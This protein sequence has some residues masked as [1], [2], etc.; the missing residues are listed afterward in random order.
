[1]LA[2][3]ESGE[4]NIGS[5]KSSNMALLKKSWSRFKVKPDAFWVRLIKSVYGEDGGFKEKGLS[6]KGCNNTWED[7][8]RIGRDL[9]EKEIH[10]AGSF[11]KE[12]GNE[13]NTRFWVDKW[14]GNFRL[15]DKY[16]RLY[17]LESQKEVLV[18]E[19]GDWSGD[20]FGVGVGKERYERF[21]CKLERYERFVCKI[22]IQ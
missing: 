5:F 8:I 13:M 18:G 15:C 17:H 14:V 16:T 11:G 20:G 12:V 9:E 3:Y 6:N 7:I 2:S 19:R 22:L 10:F 21:V 1:M 4:L